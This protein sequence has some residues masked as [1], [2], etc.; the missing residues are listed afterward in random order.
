MEIAPELFS[1]L[2]ATSGPSAP[3]WKTFRRRKWSRVWR[4]RLWARVLHFWCREWL[5]A[6][7]GGR[8]GGGEWGRVGRAG[9]GARVLPFG[10]LDGLGPDWVLPAVGAPAN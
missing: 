8:G 7:A 9:V 4:A 3:T 1:I 6:G 2:S 10:C 5:G